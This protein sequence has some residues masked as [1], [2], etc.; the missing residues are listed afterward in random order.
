MSI[1]RKDK[2]EETHSFDDIIKGF[3][4][5]V[6]SAQEMLGSQQLEMF[7]N[8]FNGDGTAKTQTIVTPANQQMQIPLV[9]LVPQQA[10][11]ID[12][13]SIEFTTRINRVSTQ[14][15]RGNML[16]GVGTPSVDHVGLLMD[17]TTTSAK[18]G[19][20]VK[21]SVKFKSVPQTEGVARILDE[22]NKRL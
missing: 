22:Q 11:A 12:E 9:T 1:F 17:I 16:Q 7:L 21:V 18:T 20:L 6:N 14:S 2:Q 8:Y 10:L 4:Y 13:V 3:Q 15:F 19:D 5:A